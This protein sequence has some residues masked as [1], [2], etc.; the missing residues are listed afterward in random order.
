MSVPKDAWE[1]AVNSTYQDV[2]KTLMS[3]VTASLVL[4]TFLVRNFVR[5][6]EGEPISNVLDRSAYWSW[7]LMF[8]S[9]VCCMVF[10]WVS[11]KYVKVLSGGPEN[12]WGCDSS[13]CFETLRDWFIRGSVLFFG[14]GLLTLGLFFVRHLRKP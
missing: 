9:L 10:F 2:M 13:S 1:F 7:A 8:L 3:L 11:A 6:P 4:P 12:W 14:A 5:A